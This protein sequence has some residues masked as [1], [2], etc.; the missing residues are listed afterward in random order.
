MCMA[1][2]T[3]SG[4]VLQVI[5]RVLDTCNGDFNE[6][7]EKLTEL[8]LTTN[9][10]PTAEQAGALLAIIHLSAH[11]VSHLS[12]HGTVHWYCTRSYKRI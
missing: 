6:A 11:D 12:L 10:S 3:R 2:P 7:L 5:S 4:D 8:S 1:M 9:S